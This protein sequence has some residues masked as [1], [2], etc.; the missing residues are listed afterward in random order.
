MHD[1]RQPSSVNR[2][3]P[4]DAE[5]FISQHKE[6]TFTLLDVRQSLEYESGHLPGALLIPLP[7]LVDSLEQLDNEKPTIVYCAVGGRSRMAAQLLAHHDFREV[8]HLEGGIEAWEGL[9]AA[10]PEEFHLQFVRGDETAQEIITVAYNM[11]RGL[12]ACHE[13]V[14]SRTKDPELAELLR[15]LISA[16]ESHMQRLMEVSSKW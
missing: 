12:R 2:I 1:T 11:E 5:A 14:R 9:A 7:L 8:Y 10:G 6:G 3:F 13:E 16:E 15:H 4:D